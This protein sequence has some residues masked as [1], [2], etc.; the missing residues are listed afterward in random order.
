MVY[1]PIGIQTFSEIRTKGFLY[2][3]KT[4]Y[5]YDVCH[6]GKFVFLS[7][8]RRFGKSLLTSTFDAYF[9]GRKDLFKGLAIEKLETEWKHYSVLH[10]DLS[11]IK[12]GTTEECE[13]N[14]HSQL[15]DFERTYGC[16]KASDELTIRFRELVKNISRK[17]ESQVVVLIDEYDAP[18]LT[19]VHDSERL[20]PMRTLLQSFY[21]PLKK[22]DQYLRFVFITGISKFSQLSIFSQIN[23]LKNISMNPKYASICG[24]TEREMMD[25]F[26]EGIAELG[27]ANNLTKDEVLAKLKFKYDGYHFAYH[28]EG[29][30]NPFSLLSAMDD[31]A[32]NNYWFSTGTPTFLVKMMKRFH[33]DLTKLDG[34]E[35][36]ADDFDAP[37]ENMHSVLPLFYQSGYLTIKGYDP[38]LSNYTLGYPNEEVKVGLMHALLPFYV[39]KD[40]VEA[41]TAA[42]KMYLALRKDDI[43]E[44]LEAARAFFAGIPYQEGTL[45]DAPTS[46]GHF[47]AML[48]VMFSFLNVYVYTQVRTAKG[49]MDILMK[50]DTT[51]YVMELKL[52]G[53]V[54][55]ALQQIDD[56]G[57]AIPYEA[58]GRRIVKVGIRFSSEE[59]TI[60]EWKIE[61]VEHTLPPYGARQTGRHCSGC[62]C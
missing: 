32:F 36:G 26:Q 34:S 3:D 55:E 10:F 41:R 2:V 42:G 39:V 16:E 5:V 44:A 14:L 17:T 33:T 25:N 15:E 57:Y 48:Y 59:R 19:V 21:S 60:T 37:T 38:I 62:S 30:Y 13:L 1:Y 50:T 27:K 61:V 40:P 31:S 52:D 35:A 43:D 58:D 46:E 8:P 24:I 45:Q 20:E 54:E 12:K 53:T 6:P 29:V 49:R 56:K 47:T 18:L 9:S 51:I 4:Q 22:L 23:N 11:D 7:R 28:S